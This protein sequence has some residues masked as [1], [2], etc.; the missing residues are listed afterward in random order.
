MVLDFL[1]KKLNRK[2]TEEGEPIPENWGPELV[3]TH[4]AVLDEDGTLR[5]IYEEKKNKRYFARRIKR[6]ICFILIVVNFIMLVTCFFVEGG[7]MSPF[8]FLNTA[9]LADYFWRSKAQ[10]LEEWK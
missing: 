2:K 3:K 1:R 4:G 7:I 5:V 9:F 8:F 6:F 10:P